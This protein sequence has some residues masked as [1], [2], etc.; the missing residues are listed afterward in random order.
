MLWLF[1]GFLFRFLFGLF[2]GCASVIEGAFD[3]WRDIIFV[4]FTSFSFRAW[5]FLADEI[6]QEI[7]LLRTNLSQDFWHQ[8]LEF[9]RL[10]W[11][12]NDKKVLANGELD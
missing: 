1:F 5:S 2:F 9:L 11:S 8:I 7:I 12:S 4:I 6:F 3:E 10:T